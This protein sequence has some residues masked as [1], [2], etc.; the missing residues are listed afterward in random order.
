[1]VLSGAA[2]LSLIAF[3]GM[4]SVPVSAQVQQG[5]NFEQI[6][7]QAREFSKRG[8]MRSHR[9]AVHL[10]VEAGDYTAFLIATADAPFAH[11]ITQ[12]Q[13]NLMVAAHQLRQAG[14]YEGARVIMEDA[15]FVRPHR[16][17]REHKVF[18]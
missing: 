14:D 2:M 8:A 17:S 9:E 5:K 1:M 6:P 13:F 4:G 12:D 11:E 10:A 18:R 3:V 16:L 7:F 15:G